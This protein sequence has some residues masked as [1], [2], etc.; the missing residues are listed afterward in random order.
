M[1]KVKVCLQKLGYKNCLPT[2]QPLIARWVNIFIT[3]GSPLSQV[4]YVLPPLVKFFCISIKILKKLIK[5]F[6]SPQLA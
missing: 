6:Y 4:N 1:L 2:C 5:R 3:S